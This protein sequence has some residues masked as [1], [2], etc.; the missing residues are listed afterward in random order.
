MVTKAELTREEAAVNEIGHTDFAPGTCVFLVVALLVM[1]LLVPALQQIHDLTAY[2]AGR[3]ASALPAGGEIFSSLPRAWRVFTN[4]K[5]SVLARTLAASDSLHADIQR[6]ETVL[7][8][9]SVVS[10]AILPPL[11]NFL[12]GQLGVGNE[13][14]YVGRHHWL[15]YRPDIDFLTGRGFLD[16]RQ[17]RKRAHSGDRWTPPPQP[18]PIR[19][20]LQFRD[21]LAKRGIQLIV[22]PTPAKSLLHPEKFSAAYEHGKA[23][24]QNPSCAAFRDV[25]GQH[26]V[27]IFDLVS[28]LAEA[29]SQTQ[30]AQFLETDTHWTP[31]AMERAVSHLKEF[32]DGNVKLTPLRS[33]EYR[34]ESAEAVNLGDI[35]VMLQLPASQRLYSRQTVRIGQVLNGHNELWRPTPA[36]EVLVLGDSFSNIYSLPAMGW[37]EGA[38][39]VEQLS[40]RLQR[41]VDC[42]LRNDAAAFAT[43]QI[44][45]REL[46]KGKDRLA[47]KKLVIWQFAMRELAFGDWKLLDMD[48]GRPKPRQFVVPPSGEPLI[49]TGIVDSIS[50]APKPG[51]VPYKD[52]IIAVHLT[53]LERGKGAVGGETVAYLWSMRDNVWTAAAR[54][55]PGQKIT[56]KLQAWSEVADK[57]E[58]INRSELSEESLQLEEPCWGDVVESGSP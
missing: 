42:I 15:F 3:R 52:H 26:G 16:P 7:A 34:S 23:P 57:L 31:E 55:R 6:C 58:R 51:S 14:A 2:R 53:D 35:A 49:V 54:Y 28:I 11:E 40:L 25:L 50:S 41:P 33:A 5:D 20:I 32:I 19:A 22:V 12:A 27:L 44:L 10:K 47:S 37:G 24:L 48:L 18:D 39:F 29:K 45:S 4:T 21:Q 36:G 8:D 17:L 30:R 56:L 38:G 13:K 43:R 46:A 9:D 1:I